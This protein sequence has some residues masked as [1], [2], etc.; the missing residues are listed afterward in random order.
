MMKQ[1]QKFGFTLIELLVVIAIISLLV[2]IL[3]PSLQKAKDLAKQAVCTTRMRSFGLAV[4]QYA[5]ENNDS[6]PLTGGIPEGGGDW[7]APYDDPHNWLRLLWPYVPSDVDPGGYCSLHP[8]SAWLCPLDV[9]VLEYNGME[10][11]NRGSYAMNIALTGFYSPS[12]RQTP[13]MLGDIPSMST[14]VLIG[15]RDGDSWACLPESIQW[16]P[17][18]FRPYPHRHQNG[19]LFVYLDAHVTLVPNLDVPGEGWPT[20]ANYRDADEYFVQDQ[21]WF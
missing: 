3:V 2:S 21:F 10:G 19:D 5:A 15:E 6:M 4:A 7:S 13:Y 8:P 1:N 17:P 16:D 11:I 20:R 9:R 18:G 12:F 14:T